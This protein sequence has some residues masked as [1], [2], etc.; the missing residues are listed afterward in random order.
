MQ[1]PLLQVEHCITT[2]WLAELSSV[3]GNSKSLRSCVDVE[4]LLPLF[5]LAPGLRDLP[6]VP[7]YQHRKPIANIA[8]RG[9][10]VACNTFCARRLCGHH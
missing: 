1:E 2:H 6:V 7:D 3:Q 5:T 9:D 4:F 10:T 8:C